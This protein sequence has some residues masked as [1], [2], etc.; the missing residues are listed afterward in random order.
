MKFEDLEPGMTLFE[1]AGL[2]WA[3]ESYY[4]IFR[5]NINSVR[6]LEVSPGLDAPHGWFS[7]LRVIL[8]SNWNLSSS[9]WMKSKKVNK[10]KFFNTLFTKIR[11][12]KKY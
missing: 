6:V 11:Y 9:G 12:L 3:E 7:E 1:K 10:R 2:G 8:K 4:I 5:K